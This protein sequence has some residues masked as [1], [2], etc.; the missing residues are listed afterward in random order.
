MVVSTGA[1]QT[2]NYHRVIATD[3]DVVQLSDDINDF[4]N[5]Y[6][7]AAPNDYTADNDVGDIYFNTTSNRL[8]VCTDATGNGTFDDGVVVDAVRT[9]GAT[10]AGKFPVGTT[11]PVSYTHLTLPTI[12]SV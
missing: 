7:A 10:G 11:V 1:N 6:R 4:N 9:T 2:Y 3:A 5:R 8:R 12:C